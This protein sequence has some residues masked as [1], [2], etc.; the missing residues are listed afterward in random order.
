M[1]DI[2][3]NWLLLHFSSIYHLLVTE[4]QNAFR[5]VLVWQERWAAMI[6]WW[7]Y[8]GVQEEGEAVIYQE[9]R[10]DK[11]TFF[12]V[13]WLLSRTSEDELDFCQ[14]AEKGK[15]KQRG[16]GVEVYDVF[17]SHW[18]ALEREMTWLCLYFGKKTEVHM[19]NDCFEETREEWFSVF[20]ALIFACFPIWC[21]CNHP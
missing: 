15:Y 9:N 10:Q 13:R 19:Q 5:G 6:T 16:G 4:I 14:K 3:G 12:P 11:M 1:S 2:N 17:T 20:F 21:F 7:T 8:G 18:K